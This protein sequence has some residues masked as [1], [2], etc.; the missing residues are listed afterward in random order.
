MVTFLQVS[1]PKSCIHLSPIRATCPAHAIRDLITQTILV[2]EYRSLSSSLCSFLHSPVN[3]SLLGPY[4]HLNILFSH[5]LW[6]RSSLNVSDHVSHPKKPTGKIKVLYI[7]IFIY[8][9][10]GDWLFQNA[11]AGHVVLVYA[12]KVC[13]GSVTLRPAFRPSSGYTGIQK[14]KLA[15]RVTITP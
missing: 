3:S 7:L 10:R 11:Y 2:E 5:T 14:Y 6:L 13:E 12:L 15:S 8:N 1:A 9:V 4:I